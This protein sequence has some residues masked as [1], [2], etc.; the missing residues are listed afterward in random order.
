MNI[1]IILIII[2]IIIVVVFLTGCW[3]YKEINEFIIVSG[4]AVDYSSVDDLYIVTIELINVS[5]GIDE[6]EAMSGETFESKG[7]SIFDAIRNMI[8]K[9]GR[10]LYWSDAAVVIISE[11]IARK[12][13]ISALDV[14][15]R[16]LE[17]RSDIFLL[18]SKED[19]AAEVLYTRDLRR[20]KVISYHLENI[21]QAQEETSKYFRVPTWIFV[22]NLYSP[23]INPTC[24][25]VKLVTYNNTT[26]HQIGETAVFKKDKLI[27]WLNEE[28]TKYFL[29]VTDNLRGGIYSMSF[30]YDSSYYDVVF[31]IFSNQTTKQAQY[32]D[33][34]LTVTIDIQTIVNINEIVLNPNVSINENIDAL[35]KIIENHIKK[36]I[37]S[38]VHIVQNKYNSDILGLG[39]T[40]KQDMPELWKNEIKNKWDTTFPKLNTEVNVNIKSRRSS[41]T[42]KTI[43]VQD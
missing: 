2:V 7:I 16:G 40:I 4:L 21:L 9:A 18:V 28:N 6:Q 17:I 42:L 38:L 20:Q 29:W 33:D 27:G 34:V 5:G 23:E 13:I 8:G 35:E 30:E 43:R 36:K 24:P 14:V 37:E 11:S 12:G 10:R 25:G 39:M 3:N 22:K 15:I 31:E 32:I 19:T 26:F 41:L 1:R